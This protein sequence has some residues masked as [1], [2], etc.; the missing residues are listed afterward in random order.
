MKDVPGGWDSSK[1][2][3]QQSVIQKIGDE[4]TTNPEHRGLHAPGEILNVRWSLHEYK[5]RCTTSAI[6]SGV[7]VAKAILWIQVWQTVAC[8]IQSNALWNTNQTWIWTSNQHD[9]SLTGTGNSLNV[10]FNWISVHR[11]MLC[12]HDDMKAMPPSVTTRPWASSC[13]VQS[14]HTI[15]VAQTCCQSFGRI[16]QFCYHPSG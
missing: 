11:I 5:P 6:C 13:A 3:L 14:S 9:T 7:Q 4:F 16:H 15:M 1:R 10:C 2:K 8:K 12:E